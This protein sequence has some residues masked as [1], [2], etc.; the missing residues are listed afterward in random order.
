[1][2]FKNNYTFQINKYLTEQLME[3][4]FSMYTE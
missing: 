3:N 2:I 4:I 1:M